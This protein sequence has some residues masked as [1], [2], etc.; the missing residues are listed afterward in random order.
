MRTEPQHRLQL[1]LNKPLFSWRAKPTVVIDGRGQPAQWGIGTWQLPDN[2][3]RAGA[4]GVMRVFVFNRLWRFGTA[5]YV[6]GEQPPAALVYTPPLLPFLR[7]QL[8]E[9]PKS[10]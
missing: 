1:T 5:V 8:R 10:P 9:A 6:F 7:G 4:S 3:G 2:A